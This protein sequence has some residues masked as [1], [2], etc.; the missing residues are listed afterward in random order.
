[1]NAKLRSLSPF[2]QSLYSSVETPVFAAISCTVKPSIMRSSFILCAIS[3]ILRSRFAV[4]VSISSFTFLSRFFGFR[5]QKKHPTQSNKTLRRVPK[6]Q[7]TRGTT[8]FAEQIRRFGIHQFLC[9]N[10]A[11][12]RGST[13]PRKT[14]LSSSR[15][16]S[17]I[18]GTFLNGSHLPPLLWKK[19]HPANSS[20]MPF[21]SHSL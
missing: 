16:G 5:V 3:F 12:R 13:G 1:M 15:L 19:A 7:L 21:I 17:Y 18:A 9:F 11:V 4:V 8:Q 14:E 6:I 2:S 20:S 10:A